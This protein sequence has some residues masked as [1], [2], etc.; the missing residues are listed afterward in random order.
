MS[1]N[2]A[3]AGSRPSASMTIADRQT[4]PLRPPAGPLAFLLILATWTRSLLSRQRVHPSQPR[5]AWG[6]PG[7]LFAGAATAILSIVC[8]MVFLDGLAIEHQRTL[9]PS[10]IR[11][12]DLITD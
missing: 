1:G 5:P 12:F 11:A 6:R 7:W 9:A 4:A 2:N 3:H 10:V 8:A